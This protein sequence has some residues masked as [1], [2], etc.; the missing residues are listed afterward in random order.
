MMREKQK[1]FVINNL[2]AALWILLALGSYH[3]ATSKERQVSTSSEPTGTEQTIHLASF[4]PSNNSEAAENP[5]FIHAAQ[6]ATPAVVHIA[7]KYKAKIVR[8]AT[9]NSPLDRLFKEFFGEEFEL[10]PK[11][12]KSQPGDSFGSGVIIA[13]D[14]YIVTN[15][16]VIADAE[17]VEVTLDDNHR[18]T[19]KV[20][21]TDPD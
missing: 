14:G 9:G 4:S 3:F 12:Y 2:V 8:G 10:G 19:A 16:H 1:Q 6:I 21:G 20:V 11:E 5:S 15:N 7:A 13:E 18:Y 17:Q